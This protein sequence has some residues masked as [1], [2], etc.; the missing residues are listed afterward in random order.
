MQQ[1]RLHKPNSLQKQVS[2]RPPQGP[3]QGWLKPKFG[4]GA[5]DLRCGIGLDRL[6]LHHRPM[7]VAILT[8]L[9]ASILTPPQTAAA[10]PLPQDVIVSSRTGV[11]PG[12]T[13]LTDGDLA[14]R[15]ESE[16]V[17]FVDQIVSEEARRGI[18]AFLE[19][20]GR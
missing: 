12:D 4:G 6:Q 14:A 8:I 20:R 19:G 11:V 10:S 17:R 1:G 18:V 5:G 3:A 15:L 7:L 16:H 9:L 2:A 13:S